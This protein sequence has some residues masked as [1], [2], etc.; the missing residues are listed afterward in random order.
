[1]EKQ[2]LAI[3][4]CFPRIKLLTRS[5][6][7]QYK[8]IQKSTH[9]PILPVYNTLSAAIRLSI[10]VFVALFLYALKWF[11]SSIFYTE[12]MYFN[13][14]HAVLYLPT[15]RHGKMQQNFKQNIQ[16]LSVQIVHKKYNKR[17]SKKSN[18]KCTIVM[19]H[20]W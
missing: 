13:I 6:F 15:K 1:M 16:T 12:L 14:S 19:L 4:H 10:Y 8:R 20:F 2:I 7:W 17:C 3:V 5:D 18:K 9:F 11:S